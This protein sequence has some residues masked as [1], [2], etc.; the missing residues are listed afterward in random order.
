[1]GICMICPKR[2]TCSERLPGLD[3]DVDDK[4]EVPILSYADTFQG[5]FSKQYPTVV[6]Q[7]EDLVVAAAVVMAVVTDPFE[8]H[9]CFWMFTL[10]KYSS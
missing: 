5:L 10:S 3:S 2:V 7:N 8:P 4:C 6:G 1:M 9:V